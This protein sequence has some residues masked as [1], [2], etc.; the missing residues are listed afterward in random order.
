MTYFEIFN[1]LVQEV[2]RFFD[3]GYFL[4]LTSDKNPLNRYSS[5]DD[6]IRLIKSGKPVFCIKLTIEPRRGGKCPNPI[7]HVSLITHSDSVEHASRNAIELLISK[8]KNSVDS[9]SGDYEHFC[10]LEI[11]KYRMQPTDVN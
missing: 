8:V 6:V 5:D 9:M 3:R 10:N 4:T 11:L 7:D 1:E 2:G